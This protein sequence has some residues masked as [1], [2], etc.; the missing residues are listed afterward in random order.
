[1]TNVTEAKPFKISF[2]FQKCPNNV[3]CCSSSPKLCS[4]SLSLSLISVSLAFSIIRLSLA[5]PPKTKPL[6]NAVNYQW[7]PRATNLCV[8]VS[9]FAQLL[10]LLFFLVKTSGYQQCRISDFAI[11]SVAVTITITHELLAL[12]W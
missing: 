3:V 10:L 12:G 8:C 9:C 2:I 7:P 5:K 11:S 4:L 1:M 6:W